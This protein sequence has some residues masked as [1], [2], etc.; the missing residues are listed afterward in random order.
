MSPAA[1]LVCLLFATKGSG[2]ITHK[3]LDKNKQIS[4]G[5]QDWLLLYRK[6]T[7]LWSS[8]RHAFIRSG[9]N[10]MTICDVTSYSRLAAIWNRILQ[11][12]I[13]KIPSNNR[14]VTGIA[15]IFVRRRQ[16][17]AW[18]WYRLS[19]NLIVICRYLNHL[20]L[21]MYLLTPTQYLCQSIYNLLR[22]H[23]HTNSYLSRVA[24]SLLEMHCF[25]LLPH[26]PWRHFRLVL[27]IIKKYEHNILKSKKIFKYS[28]V[29]AGTAECSG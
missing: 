26:A 9:W 25:Q 24:Y 1:C 21:K 18:L 4:H 23:R 8:N 27:D 29:T 7:I 3:G 19:H 20:V 17:F 16:Y 11:G 6:N 15:F 5:H 12:N 14:L 10:D 13:A 2:R 28:T 22:A